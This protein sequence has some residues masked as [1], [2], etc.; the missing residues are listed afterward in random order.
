VL[1]Y[2]CG[3]RHSARKHYDADCFLAPFEV[4][5]VLLQ[6]YF[7]S[8]SR[9]LR[10]TA[11]TSPL[12]AKAVIRARIAR[13]DS[14]TSS[15]I[16]CEDNPELFPAEVNRAARIFCVT[17]SSSGSFSDTSEIVAGAPNKKR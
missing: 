12:C 16:C 4:P 1:R 8:G 14:P 5:C 2:A 7:R 9:S 10:P 6:K 13:V 11:V 17:S 15:A 3:T